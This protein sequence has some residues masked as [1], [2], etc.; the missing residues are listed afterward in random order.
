MSKT[1]SP[2][3]GSVLHFAAAAT[4]ATTGF[5]TREE[6]AAA[7]DL[8]LDP[9][10]RFYLTMQADAG[11]VALREVGVHLPGLSFSGESLTQ[12]KLRLMQVQSARE[13][14]QA[15]LARLERA[16]T[17]HKNR[18]T[19]WVGQLDQVLISRRIDPTLP[20]P[21]KDAIATASAPFVAVAA[22]YQEAQTSAR[23]ATIDLKQQLTS[24]QTSGAQKDLVIRSLKGEQPG[25]T[26]LP[27]PPAP[28]K[29]T[30]RSRA[31]R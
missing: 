31:R 5:L 14:L 20:S 16:E 29:A 17:L 26:D 2:A 12:E 30:R 10:W 11:V 6:A 18:I 13:A 15:Q 23:R 4:A 28:R 19:E 24:A 22:H 25:P 8:A 9:S 21:I 3:P 1:Y 7:P 27:P